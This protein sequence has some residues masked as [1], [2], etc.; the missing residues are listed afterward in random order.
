MLPFSNLLGDTP[1]VAAEI[2]IQ[3]FKVKCEIETPKRLHG[4][5]HL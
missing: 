4:N 3:N 5:I 2:F 1:R